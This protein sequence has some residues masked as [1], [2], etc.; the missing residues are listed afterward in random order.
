[1]SK[2]K[3]MKLAKEGELKIHWAEDH[4]PA[5]MEIRK[6]FS[7]TKPFKNVVIG[8]TL[9][10]TKE[11]A[12]LVETLK[13]GGATVVLSPSNPLSTQDDVAA[14]LAERGINVFG[15]RGV[16]EKEYYECLRE[17]INFKPNILIDDGADL[18][19]ILHK[20]KQEY[21][22]NILGSMEET[23][24]GVI[25]LK[26]MEKDGVL[27][28]PVVAVNNAQTKML[29]DN[30]FGT[31]QSTI[32]GIL[33]AT[34]ILL[35][36]KTFVV[37]GFGNCGRGLA[38]RAEGMGCNLIVTETDPRKAIQAFY[39]GYRVMPLIE[40]AR[41]GDIFV[42]V[43]G[44][45]NVIR[46]EHIEKMK[47]GA[48]L[49]NS[50]HFNVEIDIKSL[51]KLAKGKTNVRPNLDEYT[52]PNERKIYL[53]SEGRLANLAAAEGHPSSV[54]QTSFSVQALC[55]EYILKNKGKLSNKV[56][57]VPEDIDKRVAELALSGYGIKIDKL[58]PEQEKYLK[59]WEIGT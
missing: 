40:A 30:V 11:T 47:S 29:L 17:V 12:V 36:G 1:M 26:A 50:G 35:A 37:C 56:Y 51:E 16:N 6:G 42:T 32:D 14:A 57:E 28:F 52:M 19:S 3:D 20:E 33:R 41:I 27:K 8:C 44:N 24:T 45:E 21:L 55:A 15:W 54:M 58:T 38:K 10:I 48:I 49:A 5:L 43:T 23:T 7:K 4:M 34:N 18:I 59:S 53:V 46:K 39:E 2:V 25:R 31:G 9:H 22:E 13:A